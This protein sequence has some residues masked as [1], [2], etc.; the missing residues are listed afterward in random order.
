MA[1]DFENAIG[2]KKP[3]K[4][5]QF[6][7]GRSGNPSGR[8]RTGPGIAEVV[9]RVSRQVVLTSGPKGQQRMTKLEASITQLLNKAATGDLKAMKVFLQMASR[10]L[11]LVTG[12]DAPIILQIVPVSPKP[13]VPGD[14]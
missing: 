14:H 8:P 3:P 1:D 13:K 10:H 12:P 5:S 2:Y 9:R 7:K 4:A 6:Q 11:E